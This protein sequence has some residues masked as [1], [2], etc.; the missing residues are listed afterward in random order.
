MSKITP[1]ILSGGSGTRLWPLSVEAR[2]KQ[3]LALA[4]DQTMFADTLA[5]T[6]DVDRFGPALI[7][8]AERHSALMEQE[9]ASLEGA[10]II[11]EPS[12]RN[13]APAIALAAIAAGGGDA[14]M[15]VM[16]SD[17]VIADLPAFL[18]AVDAALPAAQAGWLVTFGIEPTGPETGFGYIRMADALDGMA[19]VRK[20]ACFIEKP[21]RDVAEAM[22]AEGDHAWNAGIFLMRAD[23]YLAELAVHAPDIHRSAH[24][25]MENID[26]N[27]ALIRP[28]PDHFA[29][30]PSNSVDYAVM[31]RAQ[32][33]AVVP[34]SCGWSDVGSWDA[35]AEIATADADGNSLSGHVIALDSRNNHIQADGITVTVSGISDL[36]IVANGTHVMIVPKGRSQDV[37]KITEALKAEG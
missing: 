14:V 29:A 36:I 25:A 8:G 34:V 4:S 20:V 37:K 5:R 2:P 33:V 23:R 16:P 19:S 15:L 32:R 1:I 9:V 28:D 13:T 12:A 22:L 11:L 26:T 18:A 27:G 10:R 35:L 24:Q 30:C 31:E 6:Q 7:I 17:H 21:A 3:F